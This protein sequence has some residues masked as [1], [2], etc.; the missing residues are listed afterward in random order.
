MT[1]IAE[2]YGL[3]QG[4][5]LRSMLE[6]AGIRVEMLT[7]GAGRAYGFTIGALARVQLFVEYAHAQE[8]RRLLAQFR[9]II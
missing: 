8:A 9:E 4:E 6:A 7:S 1:Q 5:L 2:V 3:P